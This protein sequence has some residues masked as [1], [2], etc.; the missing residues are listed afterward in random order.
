MGS[1]SSLRVDRVGESRAERFACKKGA[2][3]HGGPVLQ[4][5]GDGATKK[6]GASQEKND[7]RN[8]KKEEAVAKGLCCTFLQREAAH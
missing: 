6:G 1:V 5:A 2:G 4:V 8:K 3:E 7:K